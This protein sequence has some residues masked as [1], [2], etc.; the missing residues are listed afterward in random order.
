MN[1]KQYDP[2]IQTLNDELLKQRS[3]MSKKIVK[4]CNALIKK[5]KSL[6][7]INL[8]GY[9]L[10][11]LAESY[12]LLSTDEKKFNSTL[13]KALKCLQKCEDNEMLARCYNL[14]GASALNNGTRELALNF[15]FTA[16]KYSSNM[17]KDTI[18]GIVE[19]NIGRTFFNIGDYKQAYHHIRL[20]EKGIKHNKKDSFYFRNLLLF[21]CFKAD[22]CIVLDNP[23]VVKECLEGIDKLEKDKSIPEDFFTDYPVVDIRMRANHYLGNKKKSFQYGSTLRDLI[24]SGEANLDSLEDIIETTKF[25]MRIGKP[26]EALKAVEVTEKTISKVQIPNVRMNYAMLK[27][28]LYELLGNK[29]KMNLAVNEYYTYSMLQQKQSIASYSFFADIRTLILNVEKENTRLKNQA[30]TDSLTGLGNR[31]ALNRF[32]EAAFE[33]AHKDS[34]NIAV[35]ILDFDNFKHLNDSYGHSAGDDALIKIAGEITKI[36]RKNKS[37]N[38]FRY[39]GDEFVIIYEGMTDD[40]VTGYAK[41]LRDSVNALKLKNKVDGKKCFV[42]ISQGIKNGVPTEDTRLWDYLT[43]ADNALY[44]VKKHKKGEIVLA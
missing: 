35:E 25:L 10:Y 29:R 44:E 39:G 43:L 42:T 30:E 32:V 1:I 13:L 26:E 31:F 21:Y 3:L 9:A 28:D 16:L 18:S 15:H 34:S 38:A 36:S 20:A 7:D 6:D 4:C 14:L 33:K 23:A 40:Q 37:I 11:Y 12:Y 17:E 24:L 19:Y 22:C 5:A 41:A 2:E 8:E 27:H